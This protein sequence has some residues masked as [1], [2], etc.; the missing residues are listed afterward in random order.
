MSV[1]LAPRP[2]SKGSKS[3][4]RRS[5][6]IAI[7]FIPHYRVEFFN[8]LEERLK[9]S[10]IDLTIFADHAVPQAYVSDAL[11][12]VHAAVGVSNFY[13][14]LH[15][16]L[17]SRFA[18][19]GGAS[20]RPPYWQ[21][22]FF[23]LLSF[24]LVIIEQSNSALLNY[25]LFARRRLLGDTPRIAFWGHGEN[26]Q[27]RDKGLR[28][29]IKRS[30]TKQADHW[31]VYTDLSADIVRRLDVSD[32]II[33]VVNN[34][35]D[36][37]ATKLAR[38]SDAASR[39]RKKSDLGLGDAPVAIFCARLTKNK[40]LPFLVEACRAARAE[41]GEFNLLVIG[42]GPYGPWLREQADKETWIHPMGPLYGDDKAG[43]LALAGTEA[44]ASAAL[45]AAA[46]TI[47]VTIVM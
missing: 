19:T 5:V 3:E 6:A 37:S 1:A 35:V 7:R 28:R 29:W 18:R 39:Q 26:L 21:P 14:G 32:D 46:K 41:F 2:E 12:D 20:L 47:T 8:G 40:A 44:H 27:R 10:S 16:F 38:Q 13:F 24:D 45:V 30:Q 9:T 4:A 23:R 22:I 34:S 25:P 15:D 17:G 31:F 42:Q 33:T 43:L 11:N 36:T